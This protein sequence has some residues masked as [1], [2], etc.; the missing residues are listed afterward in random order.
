MDVANV[1]TTYLPS[2]FKFR[3]LPRRKKKKKIICRNN[4][5]K[6]LSNVLHYIDEFDPHDYLFLE[7]IYIRFPCDW[8]HV[9]ANTVHRGRVVGGKDGKL[10]V[11]IDTWGDSCTAN[12]H[13]YTNKVKGVY[14]LF[15]VY[16]FNPKYKTKRRQT[17][18]EVAREV[19]QYR[20]CL[21]CRKAQ[22]IVDVNKTQGIKE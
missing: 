14:E 17:L 3:Y 18:H 7:Y 4:Y 19:I 13:K 21:V 1:N 5:K 11:W 15:D 20:C 9:H 10:V 12:L 2:I 6:S 8:G 22:Y 16:L